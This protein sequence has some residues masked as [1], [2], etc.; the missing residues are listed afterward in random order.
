MIERLA[1]D[2]NAVVVW[3]RA[4]QP[5]QSL[6]TRARKLVLPLPVAGELYAGAYSSVLRK[7]NLATVDTFVAM[8]ELV[9]PDLATARIYGEL[10]GKLADI[11]ASKMNDLWIA[12]LCLQHTL[13]LLT[14]DRGFDSIEGLRVIHW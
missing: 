2:T 5:E 8:Y 1:L 13:P 4:G 9:Q 6:L 12:A 3:F 11:R 14:N 10:R 7:K